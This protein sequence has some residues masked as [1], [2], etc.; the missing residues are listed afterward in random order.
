MRK[1]N[2]KCEICGKKVYRKPSEKGNHTCCKEHRSKLY[3]LYPEIYENNFKK[4][5]G[6]NKGMSKVN[7][8]KLSYGRPRNNKTKQLISKATRGKLR[9]ERIIK[10]CLNC[11]DK[12][13]ILPCENKKGRKFCNPECFTSYE[14]Y[15][16]KHSKFMSK[17][18]ATQKKTNTDIE[19]IL[20]TWL[21]ESK[22]SYEKNKLIE[23]IC[24]DFFIKPNIVLFADGDYWHKLSKTKERDKKQNRLLRGNGWKVIR[25]W[26]S[27]I[28]KGKRPKL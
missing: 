7:G 24:V 1:P 8:D 26:G 23:G 27:E 19:I 2:S 4:G 12:F 20:E 28:K 5:W 18:N 6:W 15:R 14:S 10:K 11:G 17:R 9:V 13:S 3:K 25:L 16:K 21:I 22:V